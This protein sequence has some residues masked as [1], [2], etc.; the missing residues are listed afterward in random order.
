MARVY[1][2]P[3]I[4]VVERSFLFIFPTCQGNTHTTTSSAGSFSAFDRQ[5]TLCGSKSR[6]AAVPSV[7]FRIWRGGW[8]FAYAWRVFRISW[9]TTVDCCREEL[10]L[11]LS[12]NAHKVFG[13]GYCSALDP[14]FAMWGSQRLA[15]IFVS[16]L[17]VEFF[18][19]GE[20][21]SGDY[22]GN[23]IPVQD[24]YILRKRAERKSG[25]DVQ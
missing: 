19:P 21:L 23:T 15:F 4:A 3:G 16:V 20:D 8:G 13:Q 7:Y 11:H 9:N 14:P 24:T 10:S 25:C 17:L 5:I 6:C 18:T 2:A 1:Q 22:R 12:H